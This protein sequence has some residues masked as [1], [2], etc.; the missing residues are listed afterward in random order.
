MLMVADIYEHKNIMRVVEAFAGL[1][2][3]VR[4]SHDLVLAG[5]AVKPGYL[6]A[7][8]GR[9]REL[10]LA[11]HFHWVGM[12]RHEELAPLYQG[13]V[14]SILPSLNETFGIPVAESMACGTPVVVSNIP[15]LSEVGGDAVLKFDPLDVEGMRGVLL[16]VMTEDSLRRSMQ[17]R[18]LKRASV[19]SPAN[20]VEKTHAVLEE[21]LSGAQVGGQG[22]GGVE[23]DRAGPV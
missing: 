10:G 19:F 14:V 7:V 23:A 18:G 12:V 22:D 4:G 17:E 15:A 1:P 3:V 8:R 6:E 2:E 9:A 21:V 16:R 13:A 5:R 20:F 11:D